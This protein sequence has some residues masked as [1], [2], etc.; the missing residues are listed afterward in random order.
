MAEKRGN[1]KKPKVIPGEW[2]AELLG[3]GSVHL[4]GATNLSPSSHAI[5]FSW[6]T[7]PAA[8]HGPNKIVLPAVVVLMAPAEVVVHEQPG[9]M[10][11]SGLMTMIDL[12]ITRALFS[13]LLPKIES[14]KMKIIRFT[15]QDGNDQKWP[16]SS[17]G[18]TLKL[19]DR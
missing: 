9:S 10:M 11:Q 5:E 1:T 15:V 17:W 12:F 18:V 13:D 7:L 2:Q 3:A 8:A 19:S 14:G 16:I 6:V 4:G